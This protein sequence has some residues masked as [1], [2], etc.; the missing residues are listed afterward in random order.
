MTEA[1]NGE[2]ETGEPVPFEESLVPGAAESSAAILVTTARRYQTLDGF[3]GAVAWFHD[4]IT[5]ETPEGL[6]EF[7][8]PELGLDILRLR[9]RFER[10]D[11]SDETTRHDVEIV[12]RATKALGKAPRIFL[13]AWSP[14]ASLKA[15]GKEKCHSEQ[16]CTLKKENGEFVYAKFADWWK[17]SIEYYRGLGIDPEFVSMQNEPDFIPPDWEGCKF[18][19]E[20]TKDFP[21]YGV[22]L[23]KMSAA[24]HELKSPPKLLGPETLG[25]HYDKVPAYLE[26]LDET[27]LYG[28]AHHLYERGNDGVWDWRF[29]GPDSYVDAMRTTAA[30][31]AKPIFQT[32]FQTDEDKG[33]DGGF[34]TAWLI[35]NSL[36]QE[37][38]TAFIYWDLI[39]D[40]KAGMVGFRGRVPTPR[41]Q[42]YSVRHFAR[43]TDPGYMRVGANSNQKALIASAYIAPDN[44]RLTIVVL[45]TSMTAMDATIGV[46]DFA[47]T[48]SAVYRTS[49]RPGH[50]K[51]WEELGSLGETRVVRLPAHSIATI[52]MQP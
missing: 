11:K 18:T 36:V 34:E 9:N 16:A 10:T 28:V 1:E 20:E 6:Y 39:W 24:L 46:D 31:T 30:A 43:F 40:G 4:R 26:H 38:V 50:S 41:D 44:T 49:F 17:R 8:F 2:S 35:H 29:P 5:G 15:S 7:L 48:T 32:E 23:E 3:G 14:P 47:A 19:P 37:G 33:T 21:G 51:R 27:L 42:Y 52:V 45:N 12:E 25:I 13:S 22:A